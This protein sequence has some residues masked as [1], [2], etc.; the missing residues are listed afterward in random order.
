MDASMYPLLVEKKEEVVAYFVQHLRNMGLPCSL[1]ENTA[2][3][4]KNI[5]DELEQALVDYIR[6]QEVGSV[7]YYYFSRLNKWISPTNVL[8]LV[9]EV[10]FKEELE[11]DTMLLDA[12][13]SG[14]I[15]P[16][17]A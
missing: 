10:K 5:K 2:E 3:S 16:K 12:I 4:I 7:P 17:V 11:L 13:R 14:L 6:G 9:Q 8:K 15:I 1:E